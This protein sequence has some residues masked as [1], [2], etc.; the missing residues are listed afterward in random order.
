MGSNN[1]RLSHKF[2]HLILWNARGIYSKLTQLKN[3]INLLEPLIVC[4][5]ETHLKE[6]YS[7]KFQNY[8]VYRKD[9]D[10]GFGGLLILTHNSITTKLNNII[11]P[12]TGD[13]EPLSIQY[14]FQNR[15]ATLI[16]LYNPCKNLSESEISSYLDQLGEIG[17]LCGDLN[18]HHESW[19][20][21]GPTPN[22]SGKSLFAALTKST[23]LRLLNPTD[24]PTRIDPH[25]GKSSNIDLIISTPQYNHLNIEVG[26]DLGSDHQSVVLFSEEK[27]LPLL[28]FRTR[29]TLKSELWCD[30][31]RS[32]KAIPDILSPRPD[33]TLQSDFASFKEYLLDCSHQ[34]FTVTNSSKPK[35]PGQPWWSETCERAVLLRKKALNKFSKRPTPNN[36]TLLNQASKNAKE[37]IKKCKEDSWS[38][39]L[40]SLNARTPASSVWKFL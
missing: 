13:L 20:L 1:R 8:T 29:W 28:Y 6:K 25:S 32:L 36:K 11:V 21:S 18:A 27:T 5:T 22:P 34:Y 33:E 30:W 35:R 37:V 3:Y 17:I 16:L 4:I 10:D 2:P 39:F 31:R 7:P 15:W 26:D 12:Q 38:T 19:E 24:L 40:S 14:N 23:D 9:R